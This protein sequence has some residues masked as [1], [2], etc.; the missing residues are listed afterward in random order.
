[1]GCICC[2]DCGCK[3]YHVQVLS[4][5]YVLDQKAGANVDGA[6]RLYVGGVLL[7]LRQRQSGEWCNVQVCV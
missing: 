7:V 5:V 4:D 3:R 1:M 6:S 2:N